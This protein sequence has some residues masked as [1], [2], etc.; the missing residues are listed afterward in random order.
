MT[1]HHDLHEFLSL[2]AHVCIAHIAFRIHSP[3]PLF[4]MKNLTTEITEHTEN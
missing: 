1:S 4:I 3:H 2:P